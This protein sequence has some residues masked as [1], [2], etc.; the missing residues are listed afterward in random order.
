MGRGT[1]PRSGYGSFVNAKIKP[2]MKTDLG[3]R[4]AKLQGQMRGLAAMV[5]DERDPTEILTLIAAIRAA[6]DGVGGML[7]T[8]QVE[9]ALSGGDLSREEVAERVQCVRTALK[10]FVS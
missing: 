2:G 6:L 7:L 8:G 3:S 5:E 4:L 10:R 9:A 1:I